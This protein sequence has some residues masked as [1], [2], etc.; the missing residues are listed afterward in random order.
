MKNVIDLPNEPKV[1]AKLKLLWDVEVFLTFS[2][3]IPLL[4]VVHSLMYKCTPQTI[5]CLPNFLHS[6]FLLEAL[7]FL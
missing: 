1:V 5:L 6:I 3:T 4:E 7:G 2:C